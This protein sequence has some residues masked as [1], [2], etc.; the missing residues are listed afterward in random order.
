[1]IRRLNL[2]IA[3]VQLQAPKA[4]HF[5]RDKKDDKQKRTMLK[6]ARL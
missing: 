3:E 2:D 5:V 6:W 1:M 4:H